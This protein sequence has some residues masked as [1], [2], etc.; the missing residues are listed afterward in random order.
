MKVCFPIFVIV[1]VVT[2]IV[3]VVV[4]V[5]TRT[6]R[7]YVMNLKNIGSHI[8]LSP[9]IIIKIVSFTVLLITYTYFVQL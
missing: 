4:V 3:I 7:L 5:V 2:V 1:I 9:K 6:L 8:N